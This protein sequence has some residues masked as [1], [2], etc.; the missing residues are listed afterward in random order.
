MR[1]GALFRKA[2]TL[3]LVRQHIAPGMP[4]AASDTPASATTAGGPDTNDLQS[5]DVA[6]LQRFAPFGEFSPR[7]ATEFWGISR[8]SAYRRL[9]HIEETGWI[10]KKGKTNTV[11]Y[12]IVA[13]GYPILKQIAP[14]VRMS[15]TR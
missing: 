7:E 6:L 9:R 2:A 4:S 8:T 10:V 14:V 12:C 3:I 1:I 15:K 11:R 13:Q 5:D